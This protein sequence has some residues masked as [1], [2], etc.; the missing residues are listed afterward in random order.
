MIRDYYYHKIV[1]RGA[2]IVVW[3]AHTMTIREI[4]SQPKQ[5]TKYRT[6]KYNI[7]SNINKQANNY[8]M[9]DHAKQKYIFGHL[10]LI[11]NLALDVPSGVATIRDVSF[12]KKRFGYLFRAPLFLGKWYGVATYYSSYKKIRK[13][14]N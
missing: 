1:E 14:T 7:P 3:M 11:Q 13:N 5:T 10:S 12:Q 6:P 9:Q 8:I 4:F 2:Y